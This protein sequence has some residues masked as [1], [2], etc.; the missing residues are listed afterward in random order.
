VRGRNDSG[1]EYEI[2]TVL[3]NLSPGGLYVRLART[4]EE[5]AKL[6]LLVRLSPSPDWTIFAPLVA[7]QGEGLRAEPQTDGRCGVA[8]RFSHRRF[9]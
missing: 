9:V 4:V 6:F 3:D 2:D 7:I 1:E 8:V 5:S